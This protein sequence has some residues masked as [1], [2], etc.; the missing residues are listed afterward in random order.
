MAT[1]L[2]YGLVR[3]HVPGHLDASA[4]ILERKQIQKRS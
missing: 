1:T 3:G 4:G 2:R